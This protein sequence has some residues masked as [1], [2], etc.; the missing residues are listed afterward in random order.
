MKR[1]LILLLSL[2]AC[3]QFPQVDQAAPQT[4]PPRPGYLTPAEVAAAIA[5]RDV[6][7]PSDL[8]AAGDALR[9]SAA[10]LRAQ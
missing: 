3:A 10:D 6:P 7:F 4:I 5:A 1:A 8:E 9:D 2:A